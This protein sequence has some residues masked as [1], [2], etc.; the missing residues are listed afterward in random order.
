MKAFLFFV[1]FALTEVVV[2]LCNNKFGDESETIQQCN[3][4][5]YSE[6]EYG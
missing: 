1:L 6:H 3:D 5:G 2:Q 4:K